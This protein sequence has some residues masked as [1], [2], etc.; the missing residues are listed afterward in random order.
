MSYKFADSLRTGSGRICPDLARKRLV[1]SIIR[2]Y[3]DARS[4]ERHVHVF[5]ET[6][7]HFHSSLFGRTCFSPA[8]FIYAW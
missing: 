8:F 5:V 3:H 1:G 2:T 6:V 4:P 7:R